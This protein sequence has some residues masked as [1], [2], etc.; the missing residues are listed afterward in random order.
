MVV[1]TLVAH[2]SPCHFPSKYH[3]LINDLPL[4]SRLE[5][6]LIF[7]RVTTSRMIL[8]TDNSPHSTYTESL[9]LSF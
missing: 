2:L 9:P 3:L 4:P 7:P 8:G 6:G 5:Q 1:V